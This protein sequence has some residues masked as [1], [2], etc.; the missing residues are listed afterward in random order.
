M[1]EIWFRRGDIDLEVVEHGAG[2]PAMLVLPEFGTG[3]LAYRR[4]I[5]G[6]GEYYRVLGMSPRGLGQSGWEAPYSLA[7]WI[8]DAVAV[9][10]RHARPPVVV[11]GHAFGAS[12]ALGVAARAPEAV[13]AVVSL[14]Q[15]LEWPAYA[16]VS[17]VLNDYWTQ[18]G[19]AVADAGGDAA[20]LTDRLATVEGREGPLGGTLDRAGLQILAHLWARQDPAVLAPMASREQYSAWVK[21]PAMLDLADRLDVP[22]LCVDGDPRA[23]GFVSDEVAARTKDLFGDV[24]QVRI[25]GA[26]HWFKL[27]SDP[28]PVVEAIRRYLE[29]R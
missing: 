11:V 22:I 24:T 20:A 25:D 5:E 9:I 19:A 26:S 17:S 1:R 15:I 4:L 23:G 16:A 28:S 7:D 3:V 27:P 14:D 2:S 18:L 8:D 10:E 29:D 12:L 21:D 13:Q 6:L